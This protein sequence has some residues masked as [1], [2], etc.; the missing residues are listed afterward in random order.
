MVGRRLWVASLATTKTSRCTRC[1]VLGAARKS[2]QA[3]AVLE[4]GQ[5]VAWGEA[6]GLGRRQAGLG[7]VGSVELVADCAAMPGHE[8]V[9]GRYNPRE[10]R[11]RLQLTIP[12]VES[13]EHCP[14][15]R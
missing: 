5:A 2:T 11:R 1:F 7:E 4:I 15:H 12:R 9:F 8:F 14:Q 6:N 13:W 3:A 10:Q